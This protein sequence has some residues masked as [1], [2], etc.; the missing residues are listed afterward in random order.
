MRFVEFYFTPSDTDLDSVTGLVGQGRLRVA[1]D[2]VV[3]LGDAARAH[4]LSETNHVKGK[5]VLTS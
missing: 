1:V 2:Q 3:P 4:E 5:I